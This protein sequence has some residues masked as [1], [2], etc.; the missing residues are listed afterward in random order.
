MCEDDVDQNNPKYQVE[1][2]DNEEVNNHNDSSLST[3]HTIA[4]KP[5]LDTSHGN[6]HS[7]K[8]SSSTTVNNDSDLILA[9]IENSYKMKN[10]HIEQLPTASATAT[11]TATPSLVPT[12]CNPRLAELKKN[13]HTPNRLSHQP[14]SNQSPATTHSPAA[15]VTAEKFSTP[16]WLK[17]KDPNNPQ[18][19]QVMLNFNYE[20][21]ME[22]LKTPT[23]V[24][25]N[26][27]RTG[28][29]TPLDELFM[30]GIQIA[31]DRNKKGL[32]HFDP[33]DSPQ[34]DY[35]F[36]KRKKQQRA[37]L[38]AEDGCMGENM[39][40]S[41]DDDIRQE[42]D[43]NR[44]QPTPAYLKHTRQVL[45]GV[46][47]YVSKKLMKDQKELAALVEYMGGEYR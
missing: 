9:A 26:A 11:T 44:I 18:A 41:N 7:N 46:N 25:R 10:K 37:Q 17:P 42:A 2:M 20:L 34:F 12:P 30:K 21:A 39:K 13:N 33:D 35:S 45:R 29:E 27:N 4:K 5:R 15:A 14:L 3:S 31:N 43:E 47:V 19:D 22:H 28:A 36:A 23:G 6:D 40:D 1:E 32:L 16:V 38:A 8:N 24:V